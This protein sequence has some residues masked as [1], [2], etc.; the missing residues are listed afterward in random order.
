MRTREFIL[1]IRF[2]RAAARFLLCAAL[3]LG[4]TGRLSPGQLKWTTYYPEPAGAFVNLVVNNNV[5]L[6]ETGGHV[7][8][9]PGQGCGFD[10]LTDSN[11]A[12][13]KPYIRPDPPIKCGSG[14]ARVTRIDGPALTDP[15]QNG[16]SFIPVLHIRGDLRVERLVWADLDVTEW[17]AETSALTVTG[18][19]VVNG[20]C[21]VKRNTP[22]TVTWNVTDAL[23]LLY[24]R[25][26]KDKDNKD[27][28]YDYWGT[29][30]DTFFTYIYTPTNYK[31][32]VGVT[33]VP[34][35]KPCA[36]TTISNKCMRPIYKVLRTDLTKPN[37]GG[38]S[39]TVPYPFTDSNPNPD[40]RLSGGSCAYTVIP[41]PD[42]KKAATDLR[43]TC[44]FTFGKDTGNPAYK[45]ALQTAP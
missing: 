17:P 39:G 4:P 42:P 14:S 20:V 23:Y 44:S 41:N 15:A 7:Y 35:E 29:K 37:A 27:V 32:S 2:S 18:C 16:S 38:A 13:P 19:I 22:L 24:T 3:F 28:I 30:F 26:E 12:A 8:V 10:P 34:P 40:M 1:R 6:A 33:P 5:R 45:F 11:S 36:D 21:T 9:A 25:T 43:G 31:Q